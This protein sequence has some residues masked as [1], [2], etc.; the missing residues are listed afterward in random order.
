MQ[1]PGRLESLSRLPGA[2][3]EEIMEWVPIVLISFKLVVLGTAMVFSIKSHHDKQ[4]E[5][6]EEERARQARASAIQL[7]KVQQ[8]V[9]ASPRARESGLG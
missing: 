8:P 9:E 7:G 3:V 6:Q 5:E 2:A 4:K 1:H